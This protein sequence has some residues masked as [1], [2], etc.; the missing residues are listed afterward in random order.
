M[1]EGFFEKL[2]IIAF[3]DIECEKPTGEVYVAMMNPE[4]YTLES[5]VEFQAAQGQ[6]TTATPAKFVFKPPQELS[7]ELLF[8]N[9]GLIDGVPRPDIAEELDLLNKFLMG[10]EGEI[11]RPKFFRFI[12]GTSLLKGVCVSLSIA[13]KL[14]NRNGIPIRAICKVTIREMKDDER[15]VAE[16]GRTS[17]DLTHYRSVRKGDTLPLM[18]YHIY[19]HSKY[20]LQVA[21]ANK[22]SNFR[23]LQAGDEIFFPPFSKEGKK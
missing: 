15:R 10:Y 16:E 22:L 9:T 3:S 21:R 17:P 18:C 11:H 13:Y 8:D 7:F 12:W 5:K 2:K 20:Y 4:N 6:G 23:E 19:G 1:P 14:F